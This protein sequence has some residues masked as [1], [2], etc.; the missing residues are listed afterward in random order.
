MIVYREQIKSLLV[1]N[2]IEL[3][4]NE[5]E[6][7]LF[8]AGLDSLQLALFILSLEKEFNIKIPVIPLDKSKFENVATI[9]QMLMELIEQ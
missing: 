6:I 4:E 1:K 8:D 3:P 7:N 5:K 9:N 2:G